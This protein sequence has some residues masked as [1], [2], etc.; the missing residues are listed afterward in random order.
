MTGNDF[1]GQT[2]TDTIEELDWITQNYILT[3]EWF[4]WSIFISISSIIYPQEKSIKKV[5]FLSA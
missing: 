4:N 5:T 3:Y 2:V 1:L